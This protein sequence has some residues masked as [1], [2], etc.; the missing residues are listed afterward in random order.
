MDV[1]HDDGLS[2]GEP[3]RLQLLSDGL[4]DMAEAQ[5][6][7]HAHTHRLRDANVELPPS[8]TRGQ[9][10][11]EPVAVDG[12]AYDEARATML[13]VEK[14]LAFDSRCRTR[15]TALE[16]KANSILRAL[17][18]RDEVD[19]YGAAEYRLGHDGQ[20][21]RRFAGDRFLSNL[22]LIQETA[23][24]RV[25]RH[26]PKGAHLHIHYNACLPA[27][28]LLDLAKTMDR[29]FVTSDLP[30]VSSDG[31]ANFDKC[32]IQFSLLSPDKERPGNVFSAEYEPRRT[33]ALA[34]FL[35]L[36]PDHYRRATADQWLAA[37]LVFHE[38]ETYNA[39]QT[40]EGAWVKFDGRTRMMKG[41][42][43]YETAF[44][45]YTR[46]F[47]EDLARDG[48]SYA[49]I[50][51]NFMASNQ[52]YRDD[53]SGPM[54][55]RAMMQLVVDEA[56]DFRRRSSLAGRFFGGIKVI[57]C[58]P[59]VFSPE[60]IA[61]ALDECLEF[62]KLWPEWIAGKL[63][64]APSCFDM[65]GQESK[66]KPLK[67][68]AKELLAFKKRCAT[69]GVDIP[70]LFHCGETL[71]VGTDTD[72]NL[73][74]ALLLG[75]KRIGHGF[76]LGRHPLLMQ[77][78]KAWGICLELCPISNEVL[79][80]TARVGGHAM[81]ALL[82][83]NVHC[84]VNSDNGTLFRSTLSHDFYQIMVGSA[85]M[86]L[87][88]WKQLAL[89]SMDHACLGDA[90]KTAVLADWQER[91]EAFLRWMMGEYGDAVGY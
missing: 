67:A 39:L 12:D 71:E 78:I 15:A 43:N 28:V 45:T 86:D 59:R 47:L 87:F 14:G 82:A 72:E 16:A 30:L 8:C 88:G 6:V 53:G 1:S 21:H 69:S 33:M 58:T 29:M 3:L 42:F 76:A 37:K 64:A 75:S 4:L 54:D 48:I 20:T 46:R 74:D 11:M 63:A 13:A 17:R 19:I 52:L 7:S 84:T 35:R 85:D 5:R 51:P 91:W 68:F 10:S 70:F 34:D 62:K 44:R 60:Q 83:N 2:P 57:Y 22:D 79:G 73:V 61:D 89:W 9:L 32:E 55:N 31:Y 18:K 41:L 24:F 90:E 38:D 81:Y 49:E 56:S 23:L 77:R 27:A 80:L 65:V 66:G 50:R 25:A 40:A 36:F 26:L